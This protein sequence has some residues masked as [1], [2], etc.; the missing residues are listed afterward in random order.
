MKK[1][2]KTPAR[3][4]H[5]SKYPKVATLPDGAVPVSEFSKIQGFKNPAYVYVKFERYQA[6]KGE[7]PGYTVINWQGINFAVPE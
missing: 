1:A 5:G 3:T 7:A 2:T 4:R 6:G